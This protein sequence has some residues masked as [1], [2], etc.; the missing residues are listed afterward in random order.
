MPLFWIQ[1]KLSVWIVHYTNEQ[2][3][4]A[5]VPQLKHDPELSEVARTHSQNMASRG[6][7]LHEL[8]GQ[9]P[10]IRGMVFGKNCSLGIAENIVEYPHTHEWLGD[11]EGDTTSEWRASSHTENA[12]LVAKGMVES[13]MW[14]SGHRANILNPRWR[15]IGV[16]VAHAPGEDRWFSDWLTFWGTQ[17]FSAC[18]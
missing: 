5:G 8:D 1:T 12:K 11:W 3:A 6:K 7:L 14:S 16:G 15:S 13:W 9:G 4:S 2:R 18:K 17:N 10:A